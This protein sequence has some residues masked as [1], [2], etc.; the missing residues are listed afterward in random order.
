MNSIT[1]FKH[2]A[3]LLIPQVVNKGSSR[4]KYFL[5]TVLP[6]REAIRKGYLI[7]PMYMSK[8][9]AETI[10]TA[11]G[12]SLSVS[13]FQWLLLNMKRGTGRKLNATGAGS[14]E[15]T[16]WQEWK[17][18]IILDFNATQFQ[19]T[20][21]CSTRGKEVCSGLS[22]SVSFTETHLTRCI[23]NYMFINWQLAA[24]I[25]RKD[26]LNVSMKLFV[27]NIKTLC[28]KRCL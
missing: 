11:L 15:K 21:E 2:E 5:R 3:F 8:F 27:R 10:E 16:T 19:Q 28:F 26:C 6:Q 1:H 18:H 25:I 12:S 23:G 17:H 20:A 9:S 24:Y 22:Y 14:G 4:P 7:Q 13:L